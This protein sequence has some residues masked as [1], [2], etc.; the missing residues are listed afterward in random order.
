MDAQQ[1]V[2]PEKSHDALEAQS[3]ESGW[4]PGFNLKHFRPRSN[5]TNRPPR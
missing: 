4:A 2:P 1:R 5:S 3:G